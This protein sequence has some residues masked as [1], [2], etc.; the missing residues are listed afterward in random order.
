MPGHPCE[1]KMSFANHIDSSVAK[2]FKDIEKSPATAIQVDILLKPLFEHLLKLRMAEHGQKSVFFGGKINPVLKE[3]RQT[4]V[5][6]NNILIAA[7]KNH[8]DDMEALK[9][10]IDNSIGPMMGKGYYEMVCSDG[11]T[12]VEERVGPK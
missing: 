3:V 9:D 6:I 1:L 7:V 8:K 4:I 11:M 5:A 12:S 10:T 2:A